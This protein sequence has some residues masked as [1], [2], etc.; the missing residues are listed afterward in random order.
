MTIE[1]PLYE[2]ME[3]A[4]W[5]GYKYHS[6]EWEE[7]DGDEK[8]QVVAQYRIHQQTESVIAHYRRKK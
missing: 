2:W 1:N 7:L 3:A 8:A 6:D 4:R 5:A